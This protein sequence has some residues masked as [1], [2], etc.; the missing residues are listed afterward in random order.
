M[1]EINIK[2]LF[3]AL[4]ATLCLASCLKKGEMNIDTED[5]TGTIMEL[6]FIE[7]GSGSTIN[8]GLQ[9]FAGGALTYPATDEADTASYNISL[10]GPA[11]LASDLAV[12]VG[13]DATKALDN[14][15]SDSI[16]YELMP[17]SLYKILSTTAT[18]AA[19][20][21]I[22]PM[23]IV[24]Y[25]SKIDITNKGVAAVEIKYKKKRK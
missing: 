11:T 6:Q 2:T 24:F 12:T 13:V 19:G 4:L 9:Y 3:V 18:I 21:R 22:A 15:K 14:F 25:P 23:Q 5:T 20:K 17:D 8:S 1:K 16:A 10:A 7:N